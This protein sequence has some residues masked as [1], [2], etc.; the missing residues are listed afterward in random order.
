MKFIWWG[1]TCSGPIKSWKSSAVLTAEKFNLWCFESNGWV[2]PV[3]FGAPDEAV[4]FDFSTSAILAL[5][6][7]TL[8]SYSFLKEEKLSAATELAEN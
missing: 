5:K 4:L 2:Y 8:E 6:A 1:D 3:A 7:A